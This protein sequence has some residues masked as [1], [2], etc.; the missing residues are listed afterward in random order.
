M[1][2]SENSGFSSDFSADNNVSDEYSYQVNTSRS[3]GAEKDDKEARLRRAKQQLRELVAHR[4]QAREEERAHI[5]REIHDELGQQ[6]TA[7]RMDATMLKLQF[8]ETVPELADYVL[9][10]KATIDNCILAVR[11]VASSLRPAVLDMGLSAAVEWL[12]N[13]FEKRTGIATVLV[14]PADELVLDDARAT[15]VF[16]VLQESLTN[17]VR[18]ARATQVQVTICHEPGSLRI[19]IADNGV[20]FDPLVVRNKRGFGL[21]GIRERVLMFG[22]IAR[23]D[24]ALGQGTTVRLTLPLV[25]LSHDNKSE[26]SESL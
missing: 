19:T 22:G 1:S 14:A 15:A 21:M 6:L 2:I 13:R 12:L 4:E 5:A 9:R 11:Q 26:D 3:G 18:H 7:L 23:F 17:I 10:M 20:G 8:G 16:R 24:S 25:N